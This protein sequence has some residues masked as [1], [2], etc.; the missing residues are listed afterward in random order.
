MPTPMM[1]VVYPVPLCRVLSREVTLSDDC[2]YDPG[3]T[4]DLFHTTLS[5]DGAKRI[6]LVNSLLASTFAES[7]S[8]VGRRYRDINSI[9]SLT[10]TILA[11]AY[12]EVTRTPYVGDSASSLSGSSDCVPLPVYPPTTPIE[13]VHC[14]MDHVYDGLPPLTSDPTTNRDFH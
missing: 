10:Y 6:V 2:Q 8:L 13:D 5:S 1:L 4:F 11:L 7:P 3:N 9:D 12:D 14:T